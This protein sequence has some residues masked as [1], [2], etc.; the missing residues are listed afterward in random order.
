M[1]VNLFICFVYLCLDELKQQWE[2]RVAQERAA[3]EEEQS[4]EIQVK[5][6]TNCVA[7]DY[8]N[9]VN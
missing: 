3:M 4:K 9:S 5:L 7:F 1:W 8:C 6:H 2:T